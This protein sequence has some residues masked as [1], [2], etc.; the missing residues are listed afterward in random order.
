MRAVVKI[1]LRVAGAAALVGWFLMLRPLSLG[2][3][4]SY[5]IV[6]GKSMLPTLHAG[7]LVLTEHHSGYE[8][9]DLV[10]YRLNGRLVIHR[11]VGGNGADGYLMR[12]DNN[13][14]VDPW[15]PTDA[16]IVGASRVVVPGGGMPLAHLRHDPLLV[17]CLAGATAL[18]LTLRH[19]AKVSVSPSPRSRRAP[20]VRAS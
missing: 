20:E 17:A 13:H 8:P 2:G 10:A 5:V 14:A 7:D 9:G 1:V 12:G 4:A 15:H 16:D 11:I 6:S 3:P 19:N 18:F